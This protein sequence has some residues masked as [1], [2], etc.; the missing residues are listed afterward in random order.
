MKSRNVNDIKERFA[1]QSN[2]L[3][4]LHEV[5]YNLGLQAVW[6]EDREI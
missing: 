4:D 2:T 5:A 6:L 1:R 3:L